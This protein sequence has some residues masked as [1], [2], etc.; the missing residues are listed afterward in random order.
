MPV[1]PRDPSVSTSPG[2]CRTFF[3]CVL[4]IRTQVLV[5]AQQVLSPTEPS[6]QPLPPAASVV[7]LYMEMEKVKLGKPGT[8]LR[9]TQVIGVTHKIQTTTG[10]QASFSSTVLAFVFPFLPK[11]TKLMCL[12]HLS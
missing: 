6:P 12:K 10:L 2:L 11:H 8:L 9:V 4:R 7:V 1:S 3:A 5:L